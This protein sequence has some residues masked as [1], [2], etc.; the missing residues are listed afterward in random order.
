MYLVG[1]SVLLKQ[2]YMNEQLEI[3]VKYAPAYIK[4]DKPNALTFDPEL[5]CV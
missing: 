3:A 4:A 2:L 1:K 5:Y